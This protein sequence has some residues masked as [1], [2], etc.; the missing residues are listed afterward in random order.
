MKNAE[1]EKL[2]DNLRGMIAGRGD[3]IDL[4]TEFRWVLS[5]IKKPQLFFGN[6]HSLLTPDSILYFEGCSI[7]PDVAKFYESHR[8]GNAVAVVRDTLFPV[9]DCFHV[10]FLP[11]VIARLCEFATARPLNELFDHV[12]AYRGESLLFTFHDAF[13]TDLLISEQV[14]ETAIAEF[15]NHIDARYR[16]ELNVN[17]RDP[18]Q[19]RWFLWALENPDKVRIAGEPWWKRIWRRLTR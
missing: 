1:R 9:P 12:K 14:S 5:G 3:G 16:R 15:S 19:L 10:S 8:A 17:K 13:T 7:A 2:K 11:E 18:E 4:N 6:L